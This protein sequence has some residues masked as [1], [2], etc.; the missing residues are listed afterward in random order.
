MLASRRQI[1]Q[2]GLRWQ[3]LMFWCLSSAP[4]RAQEVAI[5]YKSTTA[6]DPASQFLDV[7]L[8]I[9]VLMAVAALV[10]AYSRKRL[11]REGSIPAERGGHLQVLDRK[12]LSTRLTAHLIS[13]EGHKI[14]ICDSGQGVAVKELSRDRQQEA[15]DA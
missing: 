9:G 7:L 11:V 4:L 1:S 13:V 10:V 2:W 14:L 15:N 6:E 3:Q 12:V 5:P 8:I